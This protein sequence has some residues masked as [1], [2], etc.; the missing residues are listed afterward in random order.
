VKAGDRVQTPAGPGT[1]V[2]PWLSRGLHR[3]GELREDGLIVALDS[4][5]R[6]VLT[7][8]RIKALATGV[9]HDG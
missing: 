9:E 5:R 4:G 1:I 7:R 2:G 6:R 8:E 3:H